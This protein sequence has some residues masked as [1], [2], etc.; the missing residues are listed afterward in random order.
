MG[1]PC[2]LLYLDLSVVPGKFL[3]QTS[4]ADDIFRCIFFLGALRVNIVKM[5][6]TPSSFRL[7]V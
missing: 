5:F 1:P 3:S 6:C 2:L 4:S 7:C